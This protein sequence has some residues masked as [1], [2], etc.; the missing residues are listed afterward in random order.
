MWM[1]FYNELFHLD[2]SYWKDPSLFEPNSN[3]YHKIILVTDDDPTFQDEWCQ[4]HSEKIICINHFHEIRRKQLKHYIG[5]RYFPSNP[6]GG[7][8]WTYQLYHAISK[9]EKIN[10]LLQE[11]KKYIVCLG[12]SHPG[13]DVLEK[14]FTNYKEFEFIVISRRIH[15]TSIHENVKYHLNLY[16]S[17]Y[18]DILK[19]AS[20]ILCMDSNKNKTDSCTA[21][22]SIAFTFGCGLLIPDTWQ[23][24]YQF[25]NA[26]CYSSDFTYSI[27]IPYLDILK[28]KEIYSEQ[29]EHID[30]RNKIF[31]Q[32]MGSSLVY[33]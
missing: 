19:K 1:H 33:R 5:T 8:I 11:K 14:Y 7:G 28:I 12:E 32:M 26:V 22:I 2:V 31:R 4:Q 30:K 27:P 9:T 15:Q 29:K 13:G 17:T 25:Q 20:Y 21:S 6:V 23:P 3:A 16:D 24:Y 10:I 18:F